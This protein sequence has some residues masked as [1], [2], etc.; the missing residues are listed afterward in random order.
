MLRHAAPA[1]LILAFKNTVYIKY[2]STFNVNKQPG[3]LIKGLQVVS[4]GFVI[5]FNV[6]SLTV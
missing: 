4:N 3:A 2:K 1:Q 5:I 6:K